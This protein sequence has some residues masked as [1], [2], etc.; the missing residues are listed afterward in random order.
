MCNTVLDGRGGKEGK[1]E[2]ERGKQ[3]GGRGWQK[4]KERGRRMEGSNFG[5]KDL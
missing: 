3:D 2:G 4:G 1:E 5:S